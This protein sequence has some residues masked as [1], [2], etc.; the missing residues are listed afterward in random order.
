MKKVKIKRNAIFSF[1]LMLSGMLL[2]ISCTSKQPEG[3]YRVFKSEKGYE[4]MMSLY[5]EYLSKW[6]IPYQE[7]DVETSWGKTHIIKSGLN[8]K[9]PLIV[10]HGAGSNAALTCLPELARNYAVYNI[11]IIGEPGKSVP[12]RIPDKPADVANWLNE[13]FIGLNI[14]RAYILG[15]SYGGFTG[16]WFLKYHPD[17][18][19]GLVMIH[20]TYMDQKL[21]LLTFVRL[22]YYALKND[23]AS[24]QAMTEYLN[25]G[26]VKNQEFNTLFADHFYNVNLYCREGRA[27]PYESVPAAEVKKVKTPVLI[28]MGDQDPLFDAK[29][30]RDFCKQINNPYI[31]FEMIKGMGH[32]PFNHLGQVFGLVEK[33][34]IQKGVTVS[35]Q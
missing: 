27:N 34:L 25:A 16:Q 23:A 30:A 8:N 26:P 35:S 5:T 7:I 19:N 29:K 33:F 21:P 32:L 10:L 1:I 6:P 3:V 28:V 4:K 14:D 20:Y 24:V 9:K 22:A 11:D 17:K 31:R 15:M 2:Y 18:V 13:V 12:V